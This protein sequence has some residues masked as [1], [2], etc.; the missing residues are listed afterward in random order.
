MTGPQDSA[1]TG[2]AGFAEAATLDASGWV[3]SGPSS[4]FEGN[5]DDG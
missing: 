3:P 1:D 5:T 2:G 4:P